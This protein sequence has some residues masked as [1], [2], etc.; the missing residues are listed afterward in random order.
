MNI[1]LLTKADLQQLKSDILEE[2]RLLLT[3]SNNVNEWLKTAEVKQILG[4][5]TGTLQNLRIQGKLKYTKLNG[6]V[7]YNR[8]DVMELFN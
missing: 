8:K 5:S 3:D 6:T 4:C 1:E 2:I 7:Y